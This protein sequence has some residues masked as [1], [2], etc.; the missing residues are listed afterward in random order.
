MDVVSSAW[1]CVCVQWAEPGVLSHLFRRKACFINRSQHLKL[2]ML[3]LGFPSPY[4]DSNAK[5]LRY[6]AT[7]HVQVMLDFSRWNVTGHEKLR[8]W[9]FAKWVRREREAR[10][11]FCSM[12]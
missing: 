6:P 1:K 4:D 8:G 5:K 7:L 11:Q 9:W 3:I 2:F 10:V 12:S